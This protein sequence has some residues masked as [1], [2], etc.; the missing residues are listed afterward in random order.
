MKTYLVPNLA[1][2]EHRSA[3]FPTLPFHGPIRN[4]CTHQQRV[5]KAQKQGFVVKGPKM[6]ERPL[7]FQEIPKLSTFGERK[8]DGSC[9]ERKHIASREL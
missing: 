6:D 9:C 5:E 7:R 2:A 8:T 1:L 3:S 4:D